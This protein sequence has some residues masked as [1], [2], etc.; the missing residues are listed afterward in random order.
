LA[1]AE[2]VIAILADC[3][4]KVIPLGEAVTACDVLALAVTALFREV[5]G[6]ERCRLEHVAGIVAGCGDGDGEDWGWF[7]LN[8]SHIGFEFGF[9]VTAFGVVIS[10]AER[11]RRSNENHIFFIMRI[12]SS[13]YFSFALNIMESLSADLP[14]RKSPRK[15][16]DQFGFFIPAEV[17]PLIVFVCFGVPFQFRA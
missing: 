16:R 7:E 14:V 5:A 12:F 13:T 4:V 15:C 9:L 10:K 6:P 17:V 2:R 3:F 11:L 1:E 8:G